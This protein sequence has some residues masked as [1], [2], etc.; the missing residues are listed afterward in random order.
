[1]K[2]FGII[3]ASGV[4]AQHWSYGF[5][6]SGKKR[7]PDLAELDPEYPVKRMA[8]FNIHQFRRQLLPKPYY[9]GAQ[10]ALERYNIA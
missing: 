7:S 3:L 4:T 2:L 1:M 9:D 10:D 5:N 8:A 6:P